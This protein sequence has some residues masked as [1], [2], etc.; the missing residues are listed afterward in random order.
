MSSK[1][2][3]VQERV[4]RLTA[5]KELLS[6]HNL[7]VASKAVDQL[8][9]S[10]AGAKIDSFS[11]I[12]RSVDLPGLKVLK[13]GRPE[14]IEAKLEYICERWTFVLNIITSERGQVSRRRFQYEPW[15][16]RK[17]RAIFL[18]SESRTEPEYEGN[19]LGTA[20]FMQTD[21]VYK[22]LIER[23]GLKE[24]A[25]LIYA[26]ITDTTQGKVKRQ[27]WTS[28]MAQ[29]L[30][31]S[32]LPKLVDFHYCDGIQT[33]PT[34]IKIYYGNLRKYLLRHP[35]FYLRMRLGNW[36]PGLDQFASN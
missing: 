7:E 11:S 24:K 13:D 20:L 12:S 21:K 36:Q 30:G 8:I 25:D 3:A 32:D 19:G 14:T 34:F 9:S 6:R 1:M 16:Q 17:K 28:A 2:I 26:V 33:H 5:E 27:G 23:L 22:D 35:S 31:F 18:L 10:F 15:R 4:P 29:R